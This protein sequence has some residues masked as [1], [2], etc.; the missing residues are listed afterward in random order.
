MTAVA[1][2]CSHTAG[3]GVDPQHCYVSVLGQ[4]LNTP[5]KNPGVPGGNCSHVQQ[6]LITELKSSQRPDFVIAQWP[7]PIRLTVWHGGQAKNENLNHASPAFNQLLRTGEQNFY[8]PWLAAIVVCNLLCQQA[9]V[10]IIN[11]MIEDVD[12]QY[13]TAL[14]SENIVLHVDRKLPDQTWLM[15]SAASDNLHH[16]ARCHQQWANRLHGLLN[17]YT[18]Q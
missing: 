14:A 17:E 10:P 9:G 13:H 15:D 4:L 18:T 8:Q 3:V 6:A 5:I 1:L 16:S 11:I 12:S 2:G 7:N